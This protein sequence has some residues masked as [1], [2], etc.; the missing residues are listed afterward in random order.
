MLHVFFYA[1]GQH[2]NADADTVSVPSQGGVKLS[3]ADDSDGFVDEQQTV[4]KKKQKNN[5]VFSPTA[6]VG[7][8]NNKNV[9]GP[10]CDRRGLR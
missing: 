2:Q 7:P 3:E 4:L 8:I 10:G 1:I 6:L 9:W 5:P